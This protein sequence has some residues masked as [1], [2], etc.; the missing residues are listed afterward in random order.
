MLEGVLVGLIIAA[1]AFSVA[2][3]FLPRRWFGVRDAVAPKAGCDTGCGACGGCG[4]GA[5][6]SNAVAKPIT[7][8]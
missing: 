7:R 3:R 5:P 8:G 2:R 6:P 4:S 1:A